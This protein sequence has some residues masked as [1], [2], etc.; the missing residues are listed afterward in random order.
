MCLLCAPCCVPLQ[1]PIPSIS[2]EET[3]VRAGTCSDSLKVT[4]RKWGLWLTPG[5]VTLGPA[6]DVLTTPEGGV[7]ADTG[8]EDGESMVGMNEPLEELQESAF[9]KSFPSHPSFHLSVTTVTALLP[10]LP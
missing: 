10:A 4:P 1:P 9:R 5:G 3:E 6:L 7:R 2:E 8:K